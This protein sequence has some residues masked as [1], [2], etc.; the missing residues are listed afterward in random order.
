VSDTPS[1]IAHKLQI[2]L[3]DL[4]YERV[5]NT[6]SGSIEVEGVEYWFDILEEEN[7]S[8]LDILVDDAGNEYGWE[9]SS[10]VWPLRKK[11]IT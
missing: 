2:K 11:E 9:V 3:D 5:S 10:T 7:S 4:A 8:G 1:E 6:I